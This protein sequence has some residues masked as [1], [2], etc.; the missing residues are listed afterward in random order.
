MQTVNLNDL[1]GAVEWISGSSVDNEA[2][3]CRQT[4][5]IY[6]ISGDADPD[7]EERPGDVDDP[8]KYVAVPNKYELD[9]GV[10]LVFDFTKAHLIDHYHEVRSIFRR[11]GAYGR[12]KALLARHNMV[13]T[14]FSFSEERTSNALEEWCESEGFAVE[15]PDP[16]TV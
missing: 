8:D 11:R 10:R 1:Q 13:E 3:I 15:R 2:Y 5:R 12:F 6:W 16:S 14:W 7:T 9:I 4:G